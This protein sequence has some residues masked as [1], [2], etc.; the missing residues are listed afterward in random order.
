MNV[1]HV[2][3]SVARMLG[4]KDACVQGLGLISCLQVLLRESLGENPSLSITFANPLYVNQ[5][6][7]VLLR[8]KEFEVVDSEESLVAFGFL[9][10][11]VS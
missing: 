6:A 8:G 9:D 5:D 2:F 1:V 10:G 4:Y 11:A 7:K 3:K